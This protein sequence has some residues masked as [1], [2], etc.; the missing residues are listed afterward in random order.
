MNR[1]IIT[2][3]NIYV[4]LWLL[5]IMN[6]TLSIMP[7]S[8]SIMLLFLL[9]AWSLIYAAKFS[10]QKN[11]PQYIKVLNVLFALFSIYGFIRIVGGETYSIWISGNNTPVGPREFLISYWRSILPIYAFLYF[12]KKGYLTARGIIIWTFIFLVLAIIAFYGEES[13]RMANLSVGALQ[14][15]VT[16]N[17]GYAILSILP[18]IAFFRKKPV[19]QYSLFGVILVFSIMSYKRGTILIA[20]VSIIL[21]IILLW[22]N[23]NRLSF[24]KG[25]VLAC[26]LFLGAYYLINWNMENNS[27]FMMK[28]DRTI[29]GDDSGRRMIYSR[30]LDY[31]FH[32]TSFFRLLFGAGADATFK[33]VGQ[34]AHNDWLELSVDI[35]LVGLL[36]YIFYFIYFF[37]LLLDSKH[38]GEEINQCVLYLFIFCFLRSF[39]SMSINDMSLYLTMALGYSVSAVYYSESRQ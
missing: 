34:A 15:G 13:Q 7:D 37:R 31:L 8:L 3:C 16:N 18:L 26:L 29:S 5:I 12:T 6:P 11:V 39:F 20:I 14:D 27:Y 9:F 23:S 21:G 10:L 30:L 4:G 22:K 33:I 24:L 1:R 17:Q 32:Q 28:L 36:A 19:L 35:G 38:C 25:F 2:P